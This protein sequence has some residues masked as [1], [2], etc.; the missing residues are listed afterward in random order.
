[1]GAMNAMPPI[2]LPPGAAPG[3]HEGT[4]SIEQGY[5]IFTLMPSLFC[6]L[7]CPHCYLSL[8]QRKDR[9]I[10]AVDDLGTAC[11]KVDAYYGARGLKRKTV[12]CYWYGG[13]PTSMGQEYFT[14]AC[15]RING[16]FREEKGYAVKHTVLTA[17]VGVDESWFPLLAKYGKGE[18]QSSYDGLMRGK[19]YV[20]NWER[21][22]RAAVDSGLRLSTISVVNRELLDA[23]PE[24]TL[25]YLAELGIAE[26]SWLPFMWNE[27]NDSGAYAQYAPRMTEYSD[28]MIR[29]SRHWMARKAEGAAVPEI[30][31]MRFIL[32]QAEMPLLSNIAGQ[33][34]F[35]LPDGEFVLPDYREGWKEF[36]QPFGNILKQDFEAVLTSP[37]RRAYLRRQTLRNRNAECLDCDHAG[38]CVMEFWKQNRPGDE[39]FGARAYVEWALAHAPEIARL[40]PG[41]PM[42]Y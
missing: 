6:K 13:E 31:Q 12:I 11:E 16:V 36:M 7:R 5:F 14:A 26:T 2:P 18:A 40:A 28:F 20:R 3:F 29:L 39:C 25:D 32:G 9:S 15:E 17:L 19:S 42:L 1:M 21:K 24:E 41:A 34:L 23:G 10:M 4:R 33:T 35:L 8:E 27:Q 37:A 22:V 30:G 38:H